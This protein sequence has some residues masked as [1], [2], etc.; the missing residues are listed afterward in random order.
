MRVVAAGA[1]GFI[2][3]PLCAAL[4]AAGH[5]VQVLS[6][7]PARHAPSLPPGVTAL[8]WDPGQPDGDWAGAVAGAD[9]VVNLA[10]ASIASGRW[11]PARKELL[12]SSRLAA[13]SA[14]V[15]AIARA[16]E[17]SRPRVLV[18]ASA[19]GYYGDRGD[20]TLTE[21]SRPG[22]DFLARLCVE[23]EAA[24][25][26]AESL[27]L[28]VVT[29]RFGLVLGKG[30]GALPRM[31]LPFR[32]FVGGPVGS[33]RQWVS[34]IH[35][36]DVVGLVRYA[37]E[38]EVRGALNGTAPSPVRQADFASSLGRA[39]GRPS[40]APVPAFVLRRVLGEL[41]D[42]LLLPSQRVVP[43]ATLDAGYAFRHSDLLAALQ[44]AL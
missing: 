38:R 24:A 13:T 10:G 7:S 23:W 29:P 35:L 6:R 41:A 31:A 25:R 11:T 43:S 28:R 14:L 9:A 16:P 30:G 19:I 20:E 40:W 21:R 5:A 36:D 3:T 8:P 4:V 44:A 15:R 2:G 33:G 17:R 22:N 37:L 32:L 18:S 12:R 39:L 27:G 1:T 26:E 34:W 42:G